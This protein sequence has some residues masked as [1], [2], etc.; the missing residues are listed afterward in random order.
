MIVLKVRLVQNEN[1]PSS[2]ELQNELI[3]T[4]KEQSE[5]LYGKYVISD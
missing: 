2:R 5:I 4:I 3:S 1:D